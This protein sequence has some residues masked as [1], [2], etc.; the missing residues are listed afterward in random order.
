MKQITLAIDFGNTLIKVGVFIGDELTEVVELK[1][2]SIARL[3]KIIADNKIQSA[4]ISSVTAKSKSIEKVIKKI[5]PTI[6]LSEKTD[7]SI[8]ILYNEKKKL[9][10]DRLASVTAAA[11]IFPN[12]NVLTINCGTCIIYDFI[13]EK[14][15]YLGGSISPGFQMR[16]N[17]LHTFTS[18]LPK[19]KKA[20]PEKLIGSTTKESILSGVVF[21]TAKEIDG[22]IDEYK[23]LFSEVKVIVSGGDA[24]MFVPHL[25]NKIFAVPQIVLQGLYQILKFNAR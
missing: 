10:K 12:K 19:I 14:G 5:I 17:A 2:L 6:I 11:K 22:M 24:S 23:K 21:G 3:K 13:N 8:I 18:K 15:E 20:V 4:I 1:D 9:G 25:K 7:V 16:L